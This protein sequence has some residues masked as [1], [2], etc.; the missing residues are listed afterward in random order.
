MASAPRHELLRGTL[1]MMILKIIATGPSHGFAISRAIQARSDEVVMVEEGSLYPALHRLEAKGWLIAD[2][3][4]TPANRR[5]KFYTLTKTG[6][7]RLREELKEWERLVAAVR[8]V[9][10]SPRALA[11]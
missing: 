4:Q 10:D 8:K 7:G 1:E 3:R 6:A 2:W 9:L 5:A 11:E